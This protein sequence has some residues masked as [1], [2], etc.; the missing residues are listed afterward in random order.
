VHLLAV[1][2]PMRQIWLL[3][4]VFVYGYALY[5]TQGWP[6]V[7]HKKCAMVFGRALFGN[8]IGVAD[9][10]A[11]SP[12]HSSI[13]SWEEAVHV[14]EIADGPLS[15]APHQEVRRPDRFTEKIRND[16]LLEES[17]GDCI[18]L[19]VSGCFAVI[20]NHQFLLVRLLW[21]WSSPQF[22]VNPSTFAF[23]DGSGVKQCCLSTVSSSFGGSS[24]MLGLL[25]NTLQ[26]SNG[27]ARTN[28]ADQ[29]KQSREY[30][31]QVV[32]PVL[33]YRHGDRF[34]DEYGFWCICGAWL[35]SGLLI[36]FGC[37]RLWDKR[38]FGLLLFC[39]GLLLDAVATTSG[40]IGCLPWNWGRCLKD[41]QEH[42]EWKNSHGGDTVTHKLLTTPYYCNTLIAIGR[43]NM[44]NILPI[45]K[46]VAIISALAEGSGIRQIERMTG[47][48]RDTI[49]RLGVRVGQGCAALLDRKMRAL[50]C[51]RL[52]FDEIWGFIGKKERHCTTD[53]PIE[54]GDVWTFC[55]IDTDTKIVPSFRVGKRDTVTANAFVSDVASRVSNRVQVSSD[56]LRAYVEA[57]EQAFGADVDYAQIVKTYQQD[58][59]AVI[60]ERKYSAPDFVIAEKKAINGFPNLALA[61]TSHV[62]RLNGTTRLHM[63]RLTRLTYAFSKKRENF[64]AAVA[65]HFA[66]YNFVKR[67]NTLRTTPAMAAGIE[68]DFWSVGNLLEA[69]A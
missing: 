29:N 7:V 53:D 43:A 60:A 2:W 20:L 51:K 56:A 12:C 54:L 1:K 67:H 46:Q 9:P 42:S 38:R 24:G 6:I 64:E 34:S 21:R 48:H 63:R 55:A 41:G 25:L 27:Y 15:I 11:I 35:L 57:V 26:S 23:D 47:V 3:L 36:F 37:G 69:V 49:M 62:E 61:S 44:A 32:P 65:L 17:I 39:S 22:S 18:A 58:E 52:E 50:T 4:C 10:D 8:H 19:D 59:E 30:Y 45:E 14:N 68:R 33:Y 13:A 66:Y 31:I 40:V 28:S 16:L 5:G